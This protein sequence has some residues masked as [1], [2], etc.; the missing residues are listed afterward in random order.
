MEE[1][2][3]YS[4]PLIKGGQQ[5]GDENYADDDVE[6]EMAPVSPQGISMF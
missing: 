2:E 4:N 3:D 6:N 1:V 5:D